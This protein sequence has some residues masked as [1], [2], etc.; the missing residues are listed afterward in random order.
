MISKEA[1]WLEINV[2]VRLYAEKGSIKPQ[3]ATPNGGYA[4]G[5]MIGNRIAGNKDAMS[6]G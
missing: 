1:L 2:V 4:C 3:T 5:G 6:G